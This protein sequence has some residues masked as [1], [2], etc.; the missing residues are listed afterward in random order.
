TS[1]SRD[2]SSD[3]CSS[4]LARAGDRPGATEERALERGRRM[5]DRAAACEASAAAGGAPDLTACSEACELNHSNSCAR[6]ADARRAA[7]DRSEERRV[8][9]G[10]RC[11]GG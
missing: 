4:D 2:W 6:A 11:A 7:G 3:V 8:G 1:F 5:L 9:K 10:G